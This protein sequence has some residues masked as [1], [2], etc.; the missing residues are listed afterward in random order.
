MSALM[1]GI[2]LNRV[3]E[4]EYEPGEVRLNVNMTSTLA[5]MKDQELKNAAYLERIE[6][7]K[8]QLAKLRAMGEDDLV[9]RKDEMYEQERMDMEREQQKRE[10]VRRER[11][12][13]ETQ[14]RELRRR[15]INEERALKYGESNTDD[16]LVGTAGIVAVAAIG[17][18]AVGVSSSGGKG[19]DDE[20]ST[21]ET[22]SP[23]SP[24]MN[25]D[26]E[27]PK[28]Q[29]GPYEN[30][31]LSNA[32]KQD[33]LAAAMEAAGRRRVEPI[34]V[35][36]EDVKVNGNVEPYVS[37]ETAMQRYLDQDD[38]GDDWLQVVSEIIQDSDNEGDDEKAR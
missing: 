30:L 1:A 31:G 7:G 20:E 35:D 3:H 25:G 8:E 34:S 23:A 6:A 14:Q 38:G 12:L 19:T 33:G 2:P 36:G 27:V 11:Q 4:L 26:A 29:T 16:S 18:I 28:L 37:A 17:A 21:T 24:L 15:Q 22:K 5:L 13:A 32:L 9:D 10:Q